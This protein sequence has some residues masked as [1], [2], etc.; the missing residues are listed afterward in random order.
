M[1]DIS[2]IVHLKELIAD[3]VS[4]KFSKDLQKSMINN[5]LSFT[6][7]SPR[8][9]AS[10]L[11]MTTR[12]IYD[13]RD[14]RFQSTSLWF[15]VKLS[16]FLVS[17]GFDEF[18]IP[19]LEKKIELIK[20]KWVGKSIFN[21]KFPINFN[22]RNG[23][24]II[25]A[26][27]FDGG[28]TS[29]IYPFYVNKNEKLINN[30]I[31]SVEKVVGKIGYNKRTYDGVF[32]VD[33]PKILGCVL[34]KIG[35]VPG[36]KVLTNYPIPPFIIDNHNLYKEFLRQAFDDEGYVNTGDS[37]GGG[38]RI[39]FTQYHSTHRK[40]RR[41]IQIKYML[42]FLGIRASGPYFQRSYIAKNGN[43]TYGYVLQISNQ[44]DLRMFNEKVGFSMDY[45]KTDLEKLL[46]SYVSKPRFKNG[47]ISN[48][49][50]EEAKK[51]KEKGNKITIQNISKNLGISQSWTAEVT[52]K[53]I[54][55]RK[56]TV[57]KQKSTLGEFAKGFSQ[58]EFDLYPK[59]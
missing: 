10:R 46:E 34:T 20:T 28:L 6:N 56:L 3:K 18:S 54:E 16:T 21:P 25:S 1:C 57:I 4:L 42:K 41:L 58:K 53:M 35:I 43:K 45:K 14:S 17:K 51:L 12:T 23:A 24:R 30:V 36:K 33:F 2:G 40:P 19:K 31:K 38:K 9:L 52:R 22:N 32:H 59:A 55:D 48:K 7:N 47:T 50:L 44:N 8:A 15:V 26:I 29:E 49:I 13:F 27:M 5:A 37:K 11:N 39:T